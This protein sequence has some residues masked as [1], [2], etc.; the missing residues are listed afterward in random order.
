MNK[1]FKIMEMTIEQ[2]EKR[3]EYMRGYREE[4]REKLNAYSREY[5][6]NHKEY[7][8]NYYK[9]YY[10]ENKDRILMNHKLW[11]DQKSIDS[12]YCFRNIDGKVLYWGSSSRFQERISAHCT[13]NSHLKISAEQM[14]SEW[15]LDKIEYQ[16][17]SKYNLSRDDLFYL[18][19]YQKSKEKEIL[20]TA[21][22]NFNED[23]LTRSKEALEELADNVEFVEFDKLDKYLN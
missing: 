15:F 19:S 1:Q 8:Q 21:E 3:K 2:K 10:L 17:Y 22:V 23:K 11:V 16:N 6:K 13:A 9:N 20:K 5:Y 18:E 14:V 7:Y 4:N 12:I